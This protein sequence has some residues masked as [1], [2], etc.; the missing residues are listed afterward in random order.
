MVV[1]SGMAEASDMVEESDMAEASDMVDRAASG[2]V[3][4]SDLALVTLVQDT[5]AL[6]S[7][8]VLGMASGMASIISGLMALTMCFRW[9]QPLCY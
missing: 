8:L 4:I 1:A 2:M 9:S 6:V 3:A 7:V 5:S